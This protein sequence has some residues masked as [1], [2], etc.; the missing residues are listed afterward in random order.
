MYF[1]L[2]YWSNWSVQNQHTN[3]PQSLNCCHNVSWATVHVPVKWSY[4]MKPA[5]WLQHLVQPCQSLSSW[6]WVVEHL[7]V[8]RGLLRRSN[9]LH[10]C[11]RD[12]TA[13]E[14]RSH[15]NLISWELL[16]LWHQAAY[17][18]DALPLSISC[19]VELKSTLQIHHFIH[20]YSEE[21]FL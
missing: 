18:P 1:L 14:S 7:L 12:S 17:C 11:L 15:G 21:F 5:V 8:G 3:I 6:N 20:I 16:I 10:H 9:G 2:K 13:L 19:V 4:H